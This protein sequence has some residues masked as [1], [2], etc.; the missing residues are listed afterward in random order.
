MQKKI[1]TFLLVILTNNI[2]SQ[3]S[4]FRDTSI[5]EA[6]N[7]VFMKNLRKA[8]LNNDYS[9]HSF[10]GQCPDWAETKWPN[11]GRSYSNIM[12]EITG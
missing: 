6:W 12:H 8:H 10:C 7:S 9:C 2:L 1:I 4:F 3:C 11:E 5:K